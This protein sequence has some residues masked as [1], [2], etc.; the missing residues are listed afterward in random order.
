[1][2]KIIIVNQHY[3]GPFLAAILFSGQGTE[4]FG[5]DDKK[6]SEINSILDKILA[7]P[8][9]REEKWKEGGRAY[10]AHEIS[11]SDP[12]LLI[13]IVEGLNERGFSSFILE[14]F[15]VHVHDE[16]MRE[17]MDEGDKAELLASLPF[18]TLDRK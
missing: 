5:F 3:Y 11:T 4:I 14:D 17:E 6:K 10:S 13:A 8:S 15:Q 9:I 12:L 16:I 18:S 2:N 7:A 1:M